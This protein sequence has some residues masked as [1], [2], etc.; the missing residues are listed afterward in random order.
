MLLLEHLKNKEYDK[1]F[2]IAD[3]VDKSN[4]ELGLT[5]RGIIY[6]HQGNL[7]LA[8]KSY[9][10]AL[11]LNGNNYG[12]T[13]KLGQVFEIEND[14]DSAIQ[15]YQSALESNLRYPLAVSSLLK[16]SLDPKYTDQVQIVFEKLNNENDTKHM[17]H[18][19]LASFYV[20][21]N[22]LKKAEV[23]INEGLTLIPNNF[24]LLMLKAKVQANAKD[25]DSS[26]LSLDQ[27]LELSPNNINVLV[28]KA[29]I[30]DVQG[31]TEEAIKVQKAALKLMP[32]SV[33]TKLGLVNLHIKKQDISSA[34]NI[35]EGLILAGKK[36]FV[37][38][39]L[40]GKVAF[41]NRDYQR[42]EAILS[43]TFE[44]SQSA[45]VALELATSLH[46]LD[47]SV[48]ALQIIETYKSSTTLVELDVMLK[49]A[50]ILESSDPQQALNIYNTILEK[51]GRH[52]AMLNN[53]AMIYFKL[54]KPIKAVEFSKEAY[55]KAQ[56]NTTVQNTYGLA[57]LGSKDFV[58]AEKYLKQAFL[59]NQN[60]EDY[61]V[62][63][64]KALLE[65]GKVEESNALVSTVSQQSLS[66]F[67]VDMYKKLV[68]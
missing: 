19:Y 41:L 66:D 25:F 68:K 45:G 51:S 43:Q 64:A 39:R 56:S 28:A 35:L 60:N 55:E 58:N 10:Q 59:K 29:S 33:S 20:V 30:L 14:I 37:I 61:K 17:S 22:N 21:Q 16:I 3:T 8:K 36:S 5:Y 52:F 47:R 54:N 57:L 44:M 6:S 67:T 4:S 23:V 2:E 42:A 49:Q 18:I 31:N 38:D 24:N 34:S 26:L 53:I 12:V 63:Y 46:N 65:M 32:T 27:L 40:R 7:P 13:F 11:E 48:E 9:Q 1:A 50:E 15:Q 62:H